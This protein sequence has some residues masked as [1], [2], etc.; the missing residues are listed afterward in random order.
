[1]LYILASI[2]WTQQ[3]QNVNTVFDYSFSVNLT[4]FLC[5]FFWLIKVYKTTWHWTVKAKIVLLRFEHL[6]NSRIW[7]T[8]SQQTRTNEG[9]PTK[10]FSKGHKHSITRVQLKIRILAYLFVIVA[11]AR[12]VDHSFINDSKKKKTRTKWVGNFI[13]LCIFRPTSQKQKKN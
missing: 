9:N 8:F 12:Y 13:L 4:V 2:N 1:M 7:R 3:F 6:L 5:S 10:W 11:S